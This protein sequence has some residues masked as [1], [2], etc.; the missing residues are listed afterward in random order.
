MPL[1]H[2][3]AVDWERELSFM[4]PRHLPPWWGAEESSLVLLLGRSRSAKEFWP[5]EPCG[6]GGRKFPVS[7]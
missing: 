6:W 7:F 5:Q 2:R 1:C 4:S 3:Y